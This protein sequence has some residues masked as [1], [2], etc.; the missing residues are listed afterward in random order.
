[1]GNYTPTKSDGGTFKVC[2]KINS[3]KKYIG[4]NK[5]D[6]NIVKKLLTKISKLHFRERSILSKSEEREFLRYSFP[7][8][9]RQNLHVIMICF[10]DIQRM[11]ENF[12][13]F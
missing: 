5:S 4:G 12:Q 3:F 8:A 2:N 9:C 11:K 13:L 6:D 1:M 7:I 10:K